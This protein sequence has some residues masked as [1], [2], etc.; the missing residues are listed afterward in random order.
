[1]TVLKA[2]PDVKMPSITKDSNGTTWRFQIRYRHSSRHPNS[3]I[4]NKFGISS[5]VDAKSF[6][7]LCETVLKNGG[8]SVW[9]TKCS[10]LTLSDL[11]D[12]VEHYYPMVQVEVAS[13]EFATPTNDFIPPMPVIADV[14]GILPL[15]LMSPCRLFDE[16]CQSKVAS[17]ISLYSILS[18]SPLAIEMTNEIPVFSRTLFLGR[19]SVAPPLSFIAYDD[20]SNMTDHTTNESKAVTVLTLDT[21]GFPQL[22]RVLR[23]P[24]FGWGWDFGPNEGSTYYFL[25]GRKCKD[26]NLVEGQDKILIQGRNRYPLHDL[27]R[28][29]GL[30]GTATSSRC[31]TEFH[32]GYDHAKRKPYIDVYEYPLHWVENRIKPQ[33][34]R[35][36]GNKRHKTAIDIPAT[37]VLLPSSLLA[38]SSASLVNADALRGVESSA[39]GERANCV[40]VEETAVDNMDRRSFL[41]EKPAASTVLLPSSLLAI[42]SAS[43]VNADALRGVESSAEGERANCVVVEETAVD[44]M[45]R[46]SFL[47]EKPAASTVLLPSSLLAISS[48]SLVN[49]DALR[50]V[51]SSAEGERANCVVVEETAVDNMDRRSF[52]SEKPAATQGEPVEVTTDATGTGTALYNVLVVG[53]TFM[54]NMF[55]NLFSH[56]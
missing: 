47:S 1:M 11:K 43:L 2:Y 14:A 22:W 50:G 6:A 44:N 53:N 36:R 40:V 19:T 8:E 49:A 12:Y 33:V 42:S 7:K 38:I 18:S 35:P 10:M 5:C 31:Y 39:E 30:T 16:L 37:T 54:R 26:V 34:G 51:E 29:F 41:S 48:A 21:L 20:D 3:V 32:Y 24:L 23:D 17:P 56:N 13:A 46:R 28:K 4:V 52:L 55:G 27:L 45:D 25:P 9:R 15:P